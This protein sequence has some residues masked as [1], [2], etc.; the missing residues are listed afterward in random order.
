[1]KGLEAPARASD[2]LAAIHDESLVIEGYRQPDWRMTFTPQRV[3]VETTEG[4]LV[5]ERLNPRASFAG[6]TPLDA[7]G[8]H[9]GRLFQRLC[10]VDLSDDAV[11][12]DDAGLPGDRDRT[13]ERGG[14]DVARPPR[15]VS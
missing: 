5:E 6:H 4:Q 11:F 9:A 14:G 2:A 13:L 7:M 12:H 3:A 1:M 15:S 10:A 8:P